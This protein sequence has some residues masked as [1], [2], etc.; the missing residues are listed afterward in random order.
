[1]N[2]SHK[3]KYIFVHIPKTGGISI[4][5]AL[6]KSDATLSKYTHQS[7]RTIQPTLTPEQFTSY[8]KFGF[9]RNP[10]DR[11]YSMYRYNNKIILHHKKLQY[12]NSHG[13]DL[14]VLPFKD[15]LFGETW[16][17]WDPN[18]TITLPNQKL[19]QLYFLTDNDNQII[20]DYIARF[21]NII[22]EFNIICNTVAIKQHKLIKENQ[23]GP[24]INYRKQYD[25][26]MIDFVYKYHTHD[27]TQFNYHFK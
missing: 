26:E 21:E 6:E 15:W 1:M 2:I 16:N 9:V 12:Y 18:K 4:R 19:E 25:N 27:I 7:I 10:W 20:V 8:Y 11:L 24:R 13:L 14:Y 22:S 17:S 23:S 3:H 5:R